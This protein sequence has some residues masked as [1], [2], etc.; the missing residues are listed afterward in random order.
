MGVMT[1]LEPEVATFV[2]AWSEGFKDR[3]RERRRAQ[4]VA[5]DLVA[6]SRRVELPSGIVTLVDA[7]FLGELAAVCHVTGE[8]I[9]AV[10]DE[11]HLARVAQVNGLIETMPAAVVADPA[12]DAVRTEDIKALRKWRGWT[13]KALAAELGVSESSATNWN[14]GYCAP[15][16]EARQRLAALIAEMR[17]AQ[18]AGE[19]APVS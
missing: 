9:Y 16:G 5:A 11:L 14:Y 18:A 4:A 15:R 19:E 8:R 12:P 13:L 17:A 10:V 6:S 1:E 2:P 3:L 7:R